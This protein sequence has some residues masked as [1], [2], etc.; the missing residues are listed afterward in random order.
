MLPVVCRFHLCLDVVEMKLGNT[1]PPNMQDAAI[2]NVTVS[3][4][5]LPGFL[6][7]SQWN[8]EAYPSKKGALP[9]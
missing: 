1:C 5:C 9:N 4:V 6:I 7:C 2:A 8:R 3:D